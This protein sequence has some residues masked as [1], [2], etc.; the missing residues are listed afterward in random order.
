[1]IDKLLVGEDVVLSWSMGNLDY[2]GQEYDLQI[3]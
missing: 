1:M 2:W 3:L